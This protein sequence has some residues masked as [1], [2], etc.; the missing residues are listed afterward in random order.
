MVV[1]R[2]SDGTAHG[3]SETKPFKPTDQPWRRKARATSGLP[4]QS[5]STE[6]STLMS[7][8]LKQ[9]VVSEHPI[10]GEIG[11]CIEAVSSLRADLDDPVG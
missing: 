4:L 1:E 7:N 8:F 5:T 11:Q 3:G 10:S 6:L 9:V 2:P